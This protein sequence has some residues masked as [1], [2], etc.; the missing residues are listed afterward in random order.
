MAEVGGV[1][2]SPR[3]I[4]RD[5]IDHAPQRIA[6]RR[7]ITA[8]PVLLFNGTTERAGSTKGGVGLNLASGIV[9]RKSTGKRT[10]CTVELLGAT[11]GESWPVLFDLVADI[12][13]RLI[14]VDGEKGLSPLS[15]E[16]F[17]TVSRQRCLRHLSRAVVKL[18]RSK[19]RVSARVV[20]EAVA[21]LETLLADAWAERDL[22]GALGCFDRLA[23]TIELDGGVAAATHLRTAGDEVCTFLSNPT[24][25][26]LVNRPQGSPR[27]RRWCS[28]AGHAG[29]EPSERCRC[30]VVNPRTPGHPLDQAGAPVPSR[31]VVRDRARR[32]DTQGA[33]R[34]RTSTETDRRITSMSS[35]R[36]ATFSVH[37]RFNITPAVAICRALNFST[38]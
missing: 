14:V 17:A 15:A 28:G 20:D 6:P 25:G 1:S 22:A 2:V 10:S 38:S 29:D 11:L 5:V 13:P 3:T 32:H 7:D 34:P 18:L 27:R 35:E 36:L 31:T 30:P 12:T 33:D 37:N 24:A 23:D 19:D 4:R 16:R 8:V 21:N 9:A 26:Q